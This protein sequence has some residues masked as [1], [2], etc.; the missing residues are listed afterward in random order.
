MALRKS[1]LKKLK[2]PLKNLSL[3]SIL[4]VV[5]SA[6]LCTLFAILLLQNI[7]SVRQVA[8]KQTENSLK[9]F[10][11]AFAPALMQNQDNLDQFVKS[12]CNAT[13]ESDFRISIIDKNGKVIADSL[14]ENLGV[15]ENH[16]NRIEIQK[17][18]KGGEGFAIRKSTVSKNK[19]LYYATSIEIL[20]QKHAVRVAMPISSLVVYSTNIKLRIVLSAVLAF[21]VLV[22][23]SV[24]I[25]SSIIKIIDKLN[26]AAKEYQSG[27][28]DYIAKISTP[29]ELALLNN[30]M[31][32]MAKELQRLEKVRKDFVSNVSHEL[33]TPVTSIIGFS[34]TLIENSQI[35]E[36]T[37]KHF[38]SIINTQSKRLMAI[39][40]DL[41]T[42]SR[43]E[44]NKQRCETMKYNVVEVTRQIVESFLENAKQK[45]I[46]I[47]F[48]AQDKNIFAL[49]NLG[50]FEQAI[51]NLIENAI[52]YCPNDA[53]IICSVFCKTQDA[54]NK[55]IIQIEDNGNGIKEEYRER[56]FERFFRIDKGR[57]RESGGTGLGLS[58][59]RH[60]IMSHDGT[61]FATDRKDQKNGACF[62]ITLPQI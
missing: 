2:N 9:I 55:V 44:S 8:T 43:L 12:A 32:N 39:I 7:Q 48:N 56:I 60:I 59:T 34:D 16:A 4:L 53:E 10:V 35:D 11:Q 33:K 17:A 51:C 62:V 40:E 18:L 26:K 29:K 23:L 57:S 20:Q 47:L 25:S 49:L 22:L 41:L 6:I 61:I 46:K 19:V 42:L 21:F 13:A 3:S 27:N 5:N 45:N 15:L 38:L 24:F 54:Q 14:A 36:K 52:K 30:S 50:L 58:I 31:Q 28:F 37:L 1:K